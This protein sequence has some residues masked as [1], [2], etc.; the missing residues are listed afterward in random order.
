MSQ[1]SKLSPPKKVILYLIC[2]IV[3]YGRLGNQKEVPKP[4]H[5]GTHATG[6]VAVVS[7]HTW[8]MYQL[9]REL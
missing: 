2:E 8:K 1:F 9:Y 3:Q 5:I 7:L 4:G 6:V